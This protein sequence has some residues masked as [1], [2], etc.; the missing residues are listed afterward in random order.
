MIH[1]I[2][3]LVNTFLKNILSKTK[4]FPYFY[5]IN[6]TSNANLYPEKPNGIYTPNDEQIVT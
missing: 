1:R 5:A 2:L 6:R 3:F 4:A